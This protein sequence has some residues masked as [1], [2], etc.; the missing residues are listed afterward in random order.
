MSVYDSNALADD[1]VSEDREEGEDSREGCLAVYDPERDVVD[2]E[3]IGQVS[4]A[5]STLVGVRND[6]DFVS[7]IDEFLV[8]SETYGV[9]APGR[10]TLDSWYI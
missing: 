1:D 3:T 8:M 2:F 10:L 4:H 9:K 5:F 6:D 7:A